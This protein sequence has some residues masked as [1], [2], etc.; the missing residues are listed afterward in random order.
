MN[1]H[2]EGVT[3]QP[4]ISPL[5]QPNNSVGGVPAP[6]MGA[7]AMGMPFQVFPGPPP[8]VMPVSV[9]MPPPPPPQ[10]KMQQLN[11]QS[12]G[13][14]EERKSPQNQSFDPPPIGCRPEIKIPPNPMASLKRAPRPQPKGDY[15]IDE[16]RQEKMGGENEPT[17]AQYMSA[18]DDERTPSPEENVYEQ[19]KSFNEPKPQTPVMSPLPKNNVVQDLRMD[20]PKIQSPPI[21]TQSPIPANL[22]PPITPIKTPVTS[23]IKE[24]VQQPFHTQILYQQPQ[25]PQNMQQQQQQPKSNII[26]STMPQMKNS[27]LP[28]QKEVS[29]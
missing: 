24:D 19:Q 23:P 9:P 8:P 2:S 1:A 6:S 29:I 15:W 21:M 25:Q 26:I 22:P 13:N 4:K 12:N 11:N 18:E 3:N 5:A 16:Y 10:P 14:R 20:S 7:A 28:A 17:G 27:Q